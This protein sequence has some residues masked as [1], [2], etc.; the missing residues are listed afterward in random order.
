MSISKSA[1]RKSKASPIC[2]ANA[3]P[4]L[5]NR[6]AG[7]QRIYTHTK[8]N[9][10]RDFKEFQTK[11]HPGSRASGGKIARLGRVKLMPGLP[12]KTLMKTY[13]RNVISY[14]TKPLQDHILR[15]FRER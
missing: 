7:Q 12:V 10:Q 9:L 2:K 1:K 6:R 5:A 11:R 15:A 8:S 14:F 13:D 3:S 4:P